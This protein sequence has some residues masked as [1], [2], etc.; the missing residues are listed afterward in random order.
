[1]ELYEQAEVLDPNAAEVLSRLAFNY[2]NRG[3]NKKAS[4]YAARAVAVSPESSEGWIVLG[5][6]K[7]ALGDPKAGREAYRRC[8]ELGKG[9]YVEECRRVAR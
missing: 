6:A 5:A 3:D 9:A 2:L 1:M 4:E 7:H 8:V